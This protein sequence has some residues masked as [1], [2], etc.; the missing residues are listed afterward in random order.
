MSDDE[1]RLIA[2]RRAKLSKLREQGVAYPNTFR[3]SALSS[4]LQS[5][6]GAKSA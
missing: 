6:Y 4:H 2:E 1:N 3:R 5:A